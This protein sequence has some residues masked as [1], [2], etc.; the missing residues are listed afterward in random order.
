MI[1]R[2]LSRSREKLFV[3]DVVGISSSVS[4]VGLS[5]KMFCLVHLRN[6]QYKTVP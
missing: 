4:S 6:K 5:S 3:L 2:S 1:G